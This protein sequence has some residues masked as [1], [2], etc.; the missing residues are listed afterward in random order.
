IAPDVRA[1]GASSLIGAPA[2][3]AI[4]A[5]AEEVAAEVDAGTTGSDE[6][7]A[8][9]G[10][11]MGAAIALR[12]ALSRRLPVERAL[13]V[14]PSFTD[15][16]LPENLRVF[17]VIGEL[18]HRSGP[19]EG[20]ARFRETLPYRSILDASTLGADGLLTQFRAPAAAARAIRLVEIPRNRA[21][22][23][24]A[25]LAGIGLP[26]AV[27]GAPRDPVHP[28]EIAEQW[29]GGLGS[30]LTAIPARDDGR[31][32]QTAALRAAFEDW[33]TAR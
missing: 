16:S 24:E 13:F 15:R 26:T 11:S 3:F 17:P 18:L 1:H 25:E 31:P 20:Q 7:V 19:V 2:D 32:A 23:S 33:L 29:A 9:V 12:I 22:S 10:V 6:P 5:L 8:L 4:D 14:R 27:I 28:F 21:F 30:P